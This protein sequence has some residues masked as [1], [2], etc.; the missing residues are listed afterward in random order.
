MMEMWLEGPRWGRGMV[1]LVCV[2]MFKLVVSP[3]QCDYVLVKPRQ[4]VPHISLG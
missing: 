2:N 4:K 1:P 3:S